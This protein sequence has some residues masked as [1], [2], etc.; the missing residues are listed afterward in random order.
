MLN[1]TI[2]CGRNRFFDFV[3]D[4]QNPVLFRQKFSLEPILHF[5]V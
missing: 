5:N 1:Y 3:S 2:F 4:I